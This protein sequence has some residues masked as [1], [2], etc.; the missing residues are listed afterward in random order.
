MAKPTDPEFEDCEIYPPLLGNMNKTQLDKLLRSI[1]DTK[2]DFS[3]LSE[4]MIRRYYM[5][6]VLNRLIT[7]KKYPNPRCSSLYEHVRLAPDGNILICRSDL[8]VVGNASKEGFRSVWYG[9]QANELRKVV[10][11]CASCWHACESIPSGLYS[12]DV[13]TFHL[14]RLMGK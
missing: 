1:L 5:T 4:R 7:G 3:T 9:D 11:N 14:K 10:D 2:Q 6:G 8:T 12:W 13:F